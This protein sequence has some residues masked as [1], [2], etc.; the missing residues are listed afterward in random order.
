MLQLTTA[1][2]RPS[3]ALW[4]GLISPTGNS[5]I[6]LLFFS[7]WVFKFSSHTTTYGLAAAAW[8]KQDPK[9]ARRTSSLHSW[10][11]GK[12]STYAKR[13]KQYLWSRNCYSSRSAEEPSSSF[14]ASA[15]ART[16]QGTAGIRPLPRTRPTAANGQQRRPLGGTGTGPRP[17]ARLSAPRAAR[18]VTGPPRFVWRA[19]GA[20]VPPPRRLPAAMCQ[21]PLP[22][23]HNPPQK[24]V[25]VWENPGLQLE[26][27]PAVCSSKK[28][29]CKSCAHN[30]YFQLESSQTLY[31]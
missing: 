16:E 9:G 23:P 5:V 14:R 30:H 21:P 29:I 15:T 12:A 26:L 7:L 17:P 22:Y 27:N 25:C 18:P 10:E 4:W 1:S 6:P 2:D 8:R 19:E 11:E 24:K 28:A 20:F 3:T 13:W 31:R